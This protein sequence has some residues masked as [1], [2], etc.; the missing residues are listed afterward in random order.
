MVWRPK[1]RTQ[2]IVEVVEKHR[3]HWHERDA[4]CACLEWVN[5]A[6]AERDQR[7]NELEA[8]LAPPT[9]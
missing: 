5:E 3:D 8:R 7:I 4:D 6:L 2:R 1:W 9:P